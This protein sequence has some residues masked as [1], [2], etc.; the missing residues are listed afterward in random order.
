MTGLLTAGRPDLWLLYF[1]TA[2]TLLLSELLLTVQA[3]LLGFPVNCFCLF[4]LSR[5]YAVLY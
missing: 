1:S 3:V 4:F 2:L 5:V